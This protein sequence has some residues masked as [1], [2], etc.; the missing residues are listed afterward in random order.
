MEWILD[1]VADADRF[2]RRQ[3][4]AAPKTQSWAPNYMFKKDTP[5]VENAPGPVE[6]PKKHKETDQMDSRIRYFPLTHYHSKCSLTSAIP[7]PP[8]QLF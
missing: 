6:H 7:V 5:I 1:A 8:M 4:N 3:M 2:A